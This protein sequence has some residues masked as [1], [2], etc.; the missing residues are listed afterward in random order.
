MSQYWRDVLTSASA[1]D[2]TCDSIL[3]SLSLLNQVVIYF[4][5]SLSSLFKIYSSL[6]SYSS[7]QPFYVKLTTTSALVLPT[8]PLFMNTTPLWL[9]S[10]AVEIIANQTNVGRTKMEDLAVFVQSDIIAG[11]VLQFFLF[12]VQPVCSCDRGK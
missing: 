4:T 11:F 7:S 12:N 3:N 8:P 9:A 2:E 1:S 6:C 10:T 5:Q